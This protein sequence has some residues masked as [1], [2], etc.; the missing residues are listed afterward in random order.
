MSHLVRP[1]LNVDL[2]TCRTVVVDALAY[3][4]SCTRVTI[5]CLG[6]HLEGPAWGANLK[7]QK[8]RLVGDKRPQPYRDRFGKEQDVIGPRVDAEHN[9]IEVINQAATLG[10]MADALQWFVESEDFRSIPVVKCHPTTSSTSR[11]TAGTDNDLMLGAA[12]NQVIAA[13]EISDVVRPANSN[14][15]V[16]KDLRSLG[17]LRGE[18]TPFRSGQVLGTRRLFLV[19]SQELDS[20]IQRES[21]LREFKRLCHFASSALGDT[22]IIEL[23][24]IETKEPQ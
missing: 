3:L 16:V 14:N 5:G 23:S 8:V 24:A 18:R 9:F 11:S 10:R 20:F 19:V 1:I 4:Q 13:A 12:P 17:A 21:V 15:K 7:R 22:R 2:A 6:Q